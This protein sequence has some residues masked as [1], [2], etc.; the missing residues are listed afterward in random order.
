MKFH[1]YRTYRFIDKDPI[2]DACRT[3]VKD[4]KL[5]NNQA[6]VISGVSPATLAN[7]FEGETKRPNNATV[8][9]LTSVLAQ[10]LG[11]TFQQV[12]KYEKG[13]NRISGSRVIDV[14]KALRCQP[15]YFFGDANGNGKDDELH[16][17]VQRPDAVRLLRAFHRVDG[18]SIRG[19]I[20]GLVEGLGDW[21]K[22]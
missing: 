5:N 12:Q 10:K 8:T 18:T 1:I 22:K 15:A 14:A 17:L 9:A 21:Q 13:A 7:W 4:E 20:V 19:M 2:I 11:L 3:I 6:G 16:P